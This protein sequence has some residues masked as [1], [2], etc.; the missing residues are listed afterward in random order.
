MRGSGKL[1]SGLFLCRFSRFQQPLK[2]I[3]PIQK[4]DLK[5]HVRWMAKEYDCI[6]SDKTMK[7]ASYKLYIVWNGKL[8]R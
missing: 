7:E 4:K 8:R 1:L 3:L 2:I 6:H 5:G